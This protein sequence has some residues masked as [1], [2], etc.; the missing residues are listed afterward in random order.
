[1]FRRQSYSNRFC[2][3]APSPCGQSRLSD[4]T[5]SP[6][7]EAG[8]ESVAPLPGRRAQT[9]RPDPVRIPAMKAM[10]RY[11]IPSNK[12]TVSP[13]KSS[14]F[15][16]PL[17]VKKITGAESRLSLRKHGKSP[18]CKL[19]RF[20]SFSVVPSHFAAKPALL[21]QRIC[22]RPAKGF[23][24][25]KITFGKSAPPAKPGTKLGSATGLYYLCPHDNLP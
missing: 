21:R 8:N 4:L 24:P 9:F 5:K 18:N 12:K 17:R 16:I 23:F 11:E 13:H 22:T 19:S 2:R 10:Q 14:L 6:P 7:T 1:M 20:K 25:P 3:A 15:R